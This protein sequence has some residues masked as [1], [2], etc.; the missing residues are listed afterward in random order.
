MRITASEIALDSTTQKSSHTEI[1]EHITEGYVRAGDAFNKENL[2]SGSHTERVEI[3]QVSDSNKEESTYG[4]LRQK[5]AQQDEGKYSFEQLLA[6]RTNSTS[7]N[8]FELSSE[9]KMKIELLKQLFERITGKTFHVGMLDIASAESNTPSSQS[10]G[11][12]ESIEDT[13]TLA[14]GSG[15]LEHGFEYSYHESTKT[16]ELLQF[17][18][19]GKVRTDDGQVIDL[20]LNLN[21][22]RSTSDNQSL[23]IRLGAALKDPLV[24]NF[25]GKAAELTNNTLNFDIDM[26]GDNELIQQ[27]SESSGYI[28][29]DKNS[30]GEIDD[31]SELFGASSGNGFKE[32]A[33]FDDDNNGF[34][35][36]ND[37]IWDSLKIWVQHDDGSSSLFTLAEKGVGALYLGYNKTEWELSAGTNNNEM[38]GKIRASGIFLNEDGQAGTLQQVDL[39][40]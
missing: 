3:R 13:S 38:A 25:S 22:S 16:E 24:I 39:V 35:D 29:L 17:S 15:D 31:G 33:Y 32:L 30:N 2:V 14:I 9:D 20:N 40:V 6:K 4:D 8:L 21:M 1:R 27:L 19:K 36:E 18:A 11:I 26:D 7:S 34:I 12:G 23:Q 5:L 37:A 10:N 28:A